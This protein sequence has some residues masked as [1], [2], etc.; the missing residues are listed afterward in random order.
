MA[1][2]SGFIEALA[3]LGSGQ[4]RRRAVASALICRSRGLR[5]PDLTDW[6]VP[7]KS[8]DSLGLVEPIRRAVA[9]L[10]YETMTPIQEQAIPPVLEGRDVLGCAQTG[11]GKTAAFL[12]PILQHLA[13]DPLRGKPLIRA[14][15]LT[16]TRELASQIGDNFKAYAEFLKMRH[17]VIFGGV[18]QQ[19]QVS[20]LR[21]GVDVLVATPGRLLDLHVQGFI[22][23]DD[24]EFFVLDE[25]D[26][27]LDMGFI[28]DIRKVLK[29]LPKER[30]NLLFSATMPDT[31]VKLASGFL[32][33]PVRVE[34]DPQSTTV[35]RI[36]QSV[37]FVRKADKKRLLK[38]LLEDPDIE[39]AIVFT[40]TKH[41]ANRVVKDL[42]RAGVDSAAI[43]GNKSQGA[44]ERA[45]A[46]FK[47]GSI[48]VLVAT[49]IAS[50]G[51]DVDGV[52]HVFN[53]DLPNISESYVHRIGRTARAGRDGVAIAFCDES[54]TE[55]LVD[56]QKLT[57]QDLEVVDDHEWH[58]PEAIP[59]PP[60]PRSGR[61]RRS[62][63]PTQPK[64]QSNG[65]QRAKGG[66]DGQRGEGSEGQPRS[67]S[68]RR[69]RRR[70]SGGGA[71][72]AK[73]EQQSTRTSESGGQQPT[74]GERP[75]RRRRRRR[76]RPAKGPSSA[77]PKS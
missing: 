64:P 15:I 18:G 46:G 37:M 41:G 67:A 26:R 27:M 21:R 59:V 17:L 57:G 73:A 65:A 45:L 34:V 47:S 23:F 30:Q 50:R 3:H 7:L 25:A 69:R 55:Y 38:N 35:E 52:S 51:I 13:E 16:P 74:E 2:N 62:G 28:H 70:R 9:A 66:S 6:H 19:K 54:E 5:I 29:V 71:G 72:Q 48:R 33:S 31:I 77:P 75:Q 10:N 20:A 44:R 49:D 8:F 53:Y 4:S 11:T 76:R 14:L 63:K 40:R 12:L 39:S 56:I 60:A 1:L 36:D 24:I 32:R 22:S 68:R 58:Y 61:G 42:T 43:H